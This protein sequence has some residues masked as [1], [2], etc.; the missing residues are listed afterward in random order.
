LQQLISIATDAAASVHTS[1]VS[2]KASAWSGRHT[3][4]HKARALSAAKANKQCV[5]F[6]SVRA[7]AR[8]RGER[9]AAAK[10]TCAC[11]S[12][13]ARKRRRERAHTH[14][15]TLSDG[16][17]RHA[18]EAA[19]AAA[20]GAS[21]RMHTAAHKASNV[22]TQAPHAVQWCSSRKK[23]ISRRRREVHSRA[24]RRAARGTHGRGLAALRTTRQRGVGGR[25]AV[26]APHTL[27]V[28]W[29]GRSHRFRGHT[30]WVCAG[31]EPRQKARG[32]RGVLVACAMDSS[33]S[34]S[35]V[36]IILCSHHQ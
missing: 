1:R 26:A 33:S 32:A 35:A 34:S 5:C 28:L 13:Q 12:S 2:K 16:G 21:A 3:Q 10:N 31:G 9:Q 18:K 24:A 17:G 7:C 15:H 25:C 6:A 29:G 22:R 36:V 4:K 30:A 14:T 8:K 27:P 19:A 11:R 23:D 20:Q